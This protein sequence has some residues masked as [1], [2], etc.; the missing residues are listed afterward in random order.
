MYLLINLRWNYKSNTVGV[1]EI[2][3]TSVKEE[4]TMARLVR[5]RNESCEGGR[6]GGFTWSIR[7]DIAGI[8]DAKGLHGGREVLH[9][10]LFGGSAG[11]KSLIG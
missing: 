7:R 10:L 8:R 5:L 1:R 9:G 2:L 6:G 11:A 4:H 3:C